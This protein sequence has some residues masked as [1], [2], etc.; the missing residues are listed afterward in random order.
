MIERLSANSCYGR[1]SPPTSTSSDRSVRSEPRV[2]CGEVGP[3]SRTLLQIRPGAPVWGR[4]PAAAPR[5]PPAE[6][7]AR[8]S[9]PDDTVLPF[10]D[11]R[12]P[13][14]RGAQDIQTAR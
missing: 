13:R 7:L 5:P 8:W 3:A 2:G 11:T 12:W 1:P 4:P 6:G 10:V 14:L 9:S